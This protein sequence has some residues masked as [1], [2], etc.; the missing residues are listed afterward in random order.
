M[1]RLMSMSELKITEATARS[2]NVLYIYDMISAVIKQLGCVSDLRGGKNR[3]ELI[4]DVPS[5]YKDLLVSEVED[6]ISDVIS[7]NYKYSFFNKN[8]N[9]S[10]LS[11]VERE[12][13]LTALIS[14]DIDEDKKY[15]VKKLKNYSE[16]T[17]DGIFNFR[18]KAL[19]EKWADIISY[20]PAGF[21][22]KQLNDF[23]IYLIR[24]KMGKR[25]YF[26]GGQV[27]DKRYNLLKRVELLS[28]D[29]GEI[30]IVKEILLSGA[31]EV[32]LGSPLPEKDETYLKLFYGDRV[33]FNE[34]YF[35]A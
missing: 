4:I 33:R 30:S 17:L 26:D 27:Y 13:L 35:N 24:D 22:S 25:V 15:V 20:I 34:G 2:K 9:S 18:L 23:I 32:E 12:L 8:V 3:Y 21:Q 6:K 29:S 16:Y 28:G 14:A 31:G 10:G 19:K 7:V 1:H 11:A 5:S